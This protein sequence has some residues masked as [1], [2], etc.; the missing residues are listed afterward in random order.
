MIFLFD[1]ETTGLS[2]NAAPI[3]VGALILDDNLV[4]VE[5]YSTFIRP[6]EGC[7]LHPVAMA[8]H[9]E[10]GR[11]LEVLLRFGQ[12]P[13]K[14]FNKIAEMIVRYSQ[15]SGGA[16]VIPAGHNISGFDLPILRRE[17]ERYSISDVPLDYHALDSMSLAFG[18]LKFKGK[19]PNVKLE[20]LAKYYGIEFKGAGAHDAMSDVRV[21]AE[22]LRRLVA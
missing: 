4:E 19:I 5:S 20:T 14:V 16:K 7:E 10:K 11:T 18:L 3:Q 13:F 17:F 21:T 12:R 2:A 1:F 8:M 6:F 9:A 22:V 15:L